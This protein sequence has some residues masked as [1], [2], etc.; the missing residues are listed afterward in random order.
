MRVAADVRAGSIEIHA[1]TVSGGSVRRVDEDGVALLRRESRSLVQRLR[2][3][4]PAR[5]AAAAPPYGTR[6]DLVRHLAQSLADLA[7]TLEHAPR[8]PLPR[9]DDLAVADQLAVTADDVVRA[10]PG[11]DAVRGATAHVLVH[12]TDLLGE[13]VPAGLAAALGLGDV[14]AARRTV[15][16]GTPER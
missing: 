11:H 9:L 3:W 15:C 7:A 8:R 4:T 6:A 10:G 12:R 16:D 13:D 14:S 1:G 5:F 2:L